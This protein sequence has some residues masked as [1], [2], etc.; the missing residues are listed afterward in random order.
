M[1][2]YRNMSM[3]AKLL[4][5]FGVVIGLSL[6]AYYRAVNQTQV[7]MHGV[8]TTGA[9]ASRC[10]SL[11]KDASLASTK[12]AKSAMAYVFMRRQADWDAKYA[13]DDEAGNDF[14]KL[15]GQLKALPDNETLLQDLAAIETQD[16]DKCNPLENKILSL[17]KAE[18]M[19]EAQNTYET[20]YVPQRE[21]LER[22]INDFVTRLEGYADASDK[23]IADSGHE[24]QRAIYLGWIFQGVLIVVSSLLVWL[25][26][27]SISY[28]MNRLLKSAS[29]L[30]MGDVDQSLAVDSQDEI[31][32]ASQAFN[33]MVAYQK[34]M[35]AVA[36]SIATGDL[37][38][39]VRPRGE[40]DSFGRAFS[41][42]VDSLRDVVG[43]ATAAA[44]EVSRTS[45][46][47]ASE[48]AG[49]GNASGD[50]DTTISNI[51]VASEESA[52]ASSDV[53]Q[54]CS[55]QALAVAECSDLIKSLADSVRQVSGDARNAASAALEADAEADAGSGSVAE[56]IQGM[57][58]IQE[59]VNATARVIGMLGDA[60]AHIGVIVKTIDEIAEQTNLLALNA[61]IEAARAGDAGRG[62]AVVADEVRKLA[63][64]SSIATR[65]I[66]GLVQDIQTKTGEAVHVME[67]GTQQVATGTVLAERSGDALRRIR[68]VVQRVN[69]SVQEISAASLEMQ[70]SSDTVTERIV[71]IASI[72]EESSAS[73]EEMS[74]SAIE[75]ANSINSV[76]AI[77]K[78]QGDAVTKLAQSAEDLQRVAQSLAG[79]MARFK[80]D[81]SHAAAQAP[82]HRL[83]LVKAA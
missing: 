26:A 23:A 13:A 33:D 7:Y 75:V 48:A 31:G 20:Q 74:A 66:A 60:S 36:E 40:Q 16:G 56:T 61:A 57:N 1:D 14:D 39:T 51:A 35:V 50:I 17:A 42:M 83:K 63:E 70:R 82:A 2:K 38:I 5:T 34:E 37:S 46:L 72:V 8:S 73:S 4:A 80:L 27:R 11:A 76:N 69:A 9:Q 59:K 49:V 30:S 29:A 52:Q 47:L 44:A 6:I 62:F 43:S 18:K 68:T 41:A 65:E 55:Q 53:A 10:V 58:A 54:G 12:M 28:R 64:R 81:E 67:E 22:L 25:L 19:S 24:T 45:E 79:A 15:K 71:D 32:K 77:T 78:V 3:S 21:K